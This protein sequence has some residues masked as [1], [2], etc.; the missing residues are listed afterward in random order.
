[1][2]T[3]FVLLSHGAMCDG[4]KQTIEMIIGKQEKLHAIGMKEEDGVGALLLQLDSLLCRSDASFI[5]MSDLFGGS[6]NTAVYERYQDEPRVS[7]VAGINLSL[8]LEL[9]LQVD[10]CKQSIVSAIELAKNNIVSMADLKVINADD[11]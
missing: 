11:E 3:E 6:V 5:L 9:L 4:M 2:I 7:I 8:A 10:P 1:M